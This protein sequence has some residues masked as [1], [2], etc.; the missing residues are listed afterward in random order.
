VS[1]SPPLNAEKGLISFVIVYRPSR[2]EIRLSVD[3]LNLS[4]ISL[5]SYNNYP[6]IY[7]YYNYYYYLIIIVI[8]AERRESNINNSYSP[9][10]LG[11][12]RP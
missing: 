11:P 9:S 1:G 3:V 7:Y 4:T 6:G 12:I 8:I 2:T 5:L 10:D